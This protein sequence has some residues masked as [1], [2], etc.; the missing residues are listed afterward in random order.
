M[1]DQLGPKILI[2]LGPTATGKSALAIRL[3]PRFD[4]E[5]IS[6]DSMQVYRDMDIGSAKVSDTQR[7]LIP[8]HLIDIR[9]PEQPFSVAEFRKLAEEAIGGIISRGH[10]PLICGGS[11][12]YLNSL[13]APYN[14]DADSGADP[15]IREQ[16]SAEFAANGGAAM[17]TRLAAVD[18]EAASRISVND[19]RRLI[20]ALE[21]YQIT[22]R[23][24]SEL[25][26]KS[27]APPW[28]PLIIGL[29]A[30]R[31]TL[32]RR[33]EQRVDLMLAQGLVN[34]VEGLLAR[35][36]PRDA[37]SMQGLGYKQIAAYLA[38]EISLAQAADLIKRDTRRFAKRQITWFKRNSRIC[39]FTIDQYLEEGELVDAVSFRIAQM[40]EE[41]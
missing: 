33:I 22:G 32:Y 20:R 36:V 19:S 39:W 8:H 30:A 25:R 9:E 1:R 38:H 6:A 13:I 2:I 28:Q 12:L 21:V 24:I 11:G 34:E 35:G 23:P 40:L 15:Q 17:H 37:I 26:K 3:A 31:Q 16:L 4:C 10:L 41:A 27:Q 5:I 18:P 7:S 14:F 29:T